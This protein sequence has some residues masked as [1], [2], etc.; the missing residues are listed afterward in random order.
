MSIF[1]I[2]W[3]AFAAVAGFALG[4]AVALP[5]RGRLTD[6]APKRPERQRLNIHLHDGPFTS[7]HLKAALDRMDTGG[8]DRPPRKA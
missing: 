8:S 7:A 3:I 1:V 2:V 5:G 4:V 6:L